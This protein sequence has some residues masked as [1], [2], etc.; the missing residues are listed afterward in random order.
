MNR[1]QKKL[2]KSL[3]IS[4][5]PSQEHKENCKSLYMKASRTHNSTTS[6]EKLQKHH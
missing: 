5:N 3:K 6:P 2:T 1:T 4:S